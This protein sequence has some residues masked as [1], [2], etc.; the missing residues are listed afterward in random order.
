[1]TSRFNK[2]GATSRGISY[3]Y[4]MLITLISDADREEKMASCTWA[5]QHALGGIKAGEDF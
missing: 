5:V 3:F 1:L 4:A 2:A